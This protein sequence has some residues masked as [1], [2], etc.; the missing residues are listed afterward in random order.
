MVGGD[1]VFQF[2]AIFDYHFL[3]GTE[4]TGCDHDALRINSQNFIFFIFHPQT[5][6]GT[7]FHQDI[8]D[9]GVQH[10]VDV[11]LADVPHQTT[12]QEATYCRTVSR[13]MSTVNAHPAGNR[14]VIQ[15]N[16][17]I[18]QP[19][20]RFR[21]IVDKA[22]QQ[23]RVIQPLTAFQTFLIELLFAVIDT[24]HFLETGTCGIHADRRF[25]GIP[26]NAG[27]LFDNQN[28]GV[29]VAGLNGCC[30]TSTTTT[31]HHNVV[32][33]RLQTATFFQHQRF[34]GFRHR[35]GYGFFHRFTLRGC[36]RNSINVRGVGIQ[37]TGTDFFETG[38]K[39][40]IQT[41]L[42]FQYDICNPVSFQTDIDSQFIVFVLN[43][44]PEH[45]TLEFAG[46]HAA[47]IADHRV[48]QREAP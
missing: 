21:R 25:D 45:A 16:A 24:F 12:D 15:D 19:F 43:C 41:F 14:D 37:N 26:A 46:W 44:F 30:Q 27:H 31:D 6:D 35:F 4:A 17:T 38:N 36:T 32:T 13:T 1:K 3:I 33:R 23:F 11:A 40:N 48:D 42:R 7:V 47:Q 10:D 5:A 39:S 8:D 28:F 18:R 34:A 29:T 2:R 9:I 20:N 22:A